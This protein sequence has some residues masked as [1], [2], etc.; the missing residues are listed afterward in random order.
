MAKRVNDEDIRAERLLDAQNKAA[1]LFAEIETRGIIRPGVTEVQASDEIRD[2]AADMF[3]VKR[4]W[5]K[6]IV[7]SGPNT[8]QPYRKNP[9]NRE[10]AADAIAFADFGRVFDQGEAAFGRPFVLGS[11]PAKK[12]L[13]DALPVLWQAA[14]EYFLSQP[15]ITG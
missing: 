9:P 3:G 10:I 6:R 7:R 13:R 11:D 2:L 14:R 5:H 1:A 12:R 8:L 4:H 15:G